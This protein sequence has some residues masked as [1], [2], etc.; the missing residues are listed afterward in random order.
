M[1]RVALVTGASRGIGRAIA[2]ELARLHYDLL[3]NYRSDSSAASATAV[4]CAELGVKVEQG[5]GDI[6]LREDRE[7]LILQTRAQFGRLDLLV[8]NAGMAPRERADL[9]EMSETSFDEVMAVNLKGP[10]FLTQS[11][12]KWM[13]ELKRTLGA[14]YAP[15]IVTISSIS[16]YTASVN[17]GEYCISKAGLSML[18]A[19]YATRLAS[20]G[21]GVYEIRPG[22][23]ATDMTAGVKSKYDQLIDNGLT[24]IERWG[25]PE[26]VAKAISAIAQDLFPFS[27]GE[28]LNVDGGFHLRRL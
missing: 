4:A 6:A 2:L 5:R 15:K 27:T 22:V 11:A 20:H 16:A 12:A 21:V 19:L 8:S 23:I 10:F 9:L 1:S 17:R 24:P 13:I 28:V 3:L 7:A 14:D 25:Q 18:T 26:D